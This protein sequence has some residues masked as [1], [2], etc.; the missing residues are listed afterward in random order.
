MANAYLLVDTKAQSVSFRL[1]TPTKNIGHA[2]STHSLH[3]VSDVIEYS[4]AKA[5][6][7]NS[8]GQNILNF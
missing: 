6:V 8:Q 4:I 2:Y 1:Y 7:T 5:S 3:D